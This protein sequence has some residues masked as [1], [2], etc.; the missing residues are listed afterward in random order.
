MTKKKTD[1]ASLDISKYTLE[2]LLV[3]DKDKYRKYRN[4]TCVSCGKVE[5]T[6]SPS[7]ECAE[8]NTAAKR[9][10]DQQRQMNE[11]CKL[12]YTNVLFFEYDADNKACFTVTAPC[13]GTQQVMRHNNI[14]TGYK[15]RGYT[16]CLHCGGQARMQNALAHFKQK[17]GRQTRPHLNYDY[18]EAYKRRTRAVSDVY[19]LAN[20]DI[21][22]PHNFTRSND[23]GEYNLDHIVSIA[24][25]FRFGVHPAAAG[26]LRNLQMLTRDENI[27][28]TY[29]GSPENM[30]LLKEIMEHSL[31]LYAKDVP[32]NVFGVDEKEEK[33]MANLCASLFSSTDFT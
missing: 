18:F 26:H 21:I 6:S 2:E 19:Y 30:A 14:M 20:Y 24:F 27:K 9:R 16:P 11:I 33:R 25:C 32:W 12:G 15:K 5:I 4:R 1:S 22:N 23:S 7:S 31:E 10:A 8:C 13:C 3:I 29:A 28:K 17:H